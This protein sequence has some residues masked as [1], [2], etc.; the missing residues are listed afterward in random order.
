MQ[1]KLQNK[2]LKVTMP[3]LHRSARWSE[4]LVVFIIPT[5]KLT[6]RSLNKAH[7]QSDLNSAIG[8]AYCVQA[9]DC[10]YSVRSAYSTHF[11]ECAKTS[12]VH[13]TFEALHTS[14][15]N[16]NVWRA[17]GS[18]TTHS[19]KYPKRFCIVQAQS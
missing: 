12:R 11:K 3:T 6:E 16:S 2:Q 1:Q 18:K 4:K 10:S 8:T 19:K 14:I 7:K 13:C 5:L 9:K 17:E 15:S